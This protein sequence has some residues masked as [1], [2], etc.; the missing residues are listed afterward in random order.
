MG[1]S[2]DLLSLL[3]KNKT[4]NKKKKTVGTRGKVCE[5]IKNNFNLKI[6]DHL[7]YLFLLG[8]SGAIRELI[9][10]LLKTCEITR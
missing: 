7:I 6:K 2:Q 8:F 4:N 9:T 1:G 3:R 5:L 10:A